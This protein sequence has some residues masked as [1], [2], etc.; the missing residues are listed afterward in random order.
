MSAVLALRLDLK[1]SH[2]LAGL[3]VAA[4]GLALAA[5]WVSLAGWAR[6]LAAAAIL[7]SLVHSV[8]RVLHRVGASTV[9]LE[10]REDGRASWRNRDGRWH[11]GKLGRNHFVSAA[12]V[13]LE[14]EPGGR[15]RKW[16]VFMQDSTSPEDFRRLRVW[17]RWRRSAG[18]PEPQ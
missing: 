6:Y 7:V 18:R 1:P 12:L 8:A 4:H 10:L 5:A 2:R 3:L 17:L 16:I 11:E 13:V 14:L 15:G 9:S